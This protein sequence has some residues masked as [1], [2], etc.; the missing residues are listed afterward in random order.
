MNTKRKFEK[1]K[2]RIIFTN[3]SV[4]KDKVEVP[5]YLKYLFG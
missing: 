2:W 4:L 1:S 5:E 3:I